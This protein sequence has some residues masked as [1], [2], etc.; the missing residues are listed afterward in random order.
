MHQPAVAVFF[1]KYLAIFQIGG[2]RRS[3]QRNQGGGLA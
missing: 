2:M 3:A 1:A